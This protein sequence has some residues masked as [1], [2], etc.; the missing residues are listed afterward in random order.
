MGVWIDL[1]IS[2]LKVRV[3]CPVARG[4]ND[5]AS[6]AWAAKR[7]AATK[8]NFWT[9]SC[10]N[11]ILLF[12][13]SPSFFYGGA[14]GSVAAPLTSTQSKAHSR[15]I[16]N[17]VGFVSFSLSSSLF[18][19]SSS[20]FSFFLSMFLLKVN[21]P[22]SFFTFSYGHTHQKTPDPVR[23]PKLSWWWLSQYCGGGPHGNTGCCNFCPLLMPSSSH[24]A[25]YISR[26]VVF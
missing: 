9:Q 19:L 26:V 18:S 15:F 11:K 7:G 20:L 23:S 14:A 25:M 12:L 16:I 17:G 6:A 3:R 2:F 1:E 10:G 5:A 4:E 22:K 13:P 24:V 21:K 8:V